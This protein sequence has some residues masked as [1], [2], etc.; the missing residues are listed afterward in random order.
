MLQPL[1]RT[2]DLY[3]DEDC[4]K[5]DASLSR[6]GTVRRQKKYESPHAIW[7]R[8]V[9][10]SI[11]EK[12]VKNSISMTASMPIFRT[13][14]HCS[15]RTSREPEK[16]VRRDR[17]HISL[18]ND[19]HRVE[20]EAVVFKYDEVNVFTSDHFDRTTELRDR[21]ERLSPAPRT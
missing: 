18:G 17:Y 5:A 15:Q 8:S 20:N 16:T 12:R 21:R 6:R 7:R 10:V 3:G 13:R 2:S 9:N 1:L 14:M 19:F 11:A 4:I